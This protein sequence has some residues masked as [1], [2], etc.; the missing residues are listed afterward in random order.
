MIDATFEEGAERPLALRAETDED[1]GV[2]SALVQ[3]AVLPITEIHYDRRRRELALLINRFRWEDRSA[4]EARGRAYER[5]QSVLLVG[6]AM[7]V[8][9][10]GIDRNARDMILSVLSLAWE[11]G[12]DGT[13]RLVV[14]LAGDGAIA[15]SAECLN[16]ALKDVTRPY[17]ALSKK[18]PSH[19][20]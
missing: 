17:A 19:P 8:A 7:G 14:T 20:V 13:G 11:P 4:A 18:A 15:V 2:I 16:V 1:L 6:D 10:Q 9:S 12:E 5:V 3:D